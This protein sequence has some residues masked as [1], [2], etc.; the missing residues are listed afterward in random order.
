V[1]RTSISISILSLHQV[2]LRLFIIDI[3]KTFAWLNGLEKCPGEPRLGT[4]AACTWDRRRW[5]ALQMLHAYISIST[6]IYIY[7]PACIPTCMG[8]CKCIW[9][10]RIC[11]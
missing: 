1:P 3:P 6:A 11:I 5:E 8:N 10:T 2:D 4:T 7:T 9:H